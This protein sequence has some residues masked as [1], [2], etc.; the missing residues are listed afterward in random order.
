MT[1]LNKKSSNEQLNEDL[2]PVDTRIDTQKLNES[3]D[4]I[5]LD[6]PMI[7]KKENPNAQNRC[8]SKL[9]GSSQKM[10]GTIQVFK[11][12]TIVA[13]SEKTQLLSQTSQG[14][15]LKYGNAAMCYIHICKRLHN[16]VG[17]TI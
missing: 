16:Y 4:S 14:A 7:I 6:D 5:D 8:L 15:S 13:P 12:A 3:L 9:Y 2:A 10:V 11:N 17:A 1:S